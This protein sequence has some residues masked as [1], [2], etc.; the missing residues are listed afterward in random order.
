MILP[1]LVVISIAGYWITRWSISAASSIMIAKGM[2]GKDILK[3]Q[4]PKIAEAAGAIVGTVYFVSMFLFI[5]IPF[6]DWHNQ[7][8]NS[9][10][11]PHDKFAQMLGGLL[12]ILAMLFL[13]F[14]DDVLDI[15]WRIKIWF[16]LIASI[17]LLM[18]YYVTYGVTDVLIPM[19]LR[20]LFSTPVI[21]LGPF[22]YVYISL[23]CVFSTNA[24]N[25]LAGSN[26]VEGSQA[27][28]IAGSLIVQLLID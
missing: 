6:I 23:L 3:K 21:H 18:V 20:S 24:I 10:M 22:Y 11:F 12:S 19:P 4:Q 28:I 8:Y 1:I 2:F 7:L 14:A 5:P 16:P 17:P 15:K 27:V 9:S 26:G 25:I 13:G